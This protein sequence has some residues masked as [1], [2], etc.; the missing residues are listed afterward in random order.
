LKILYFLFAEA[1][2]RRRHFAGA[3]A[4]GKKHPA[5]RRRLIQTGADLLIS[6][7]SSSKLIFAYF[8]VVRGNVNKAE[9]HKNKKYTY[10]MSDYDGE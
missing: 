10:K 7:S 6:S 3:A 2:D 8:D 5:R 9:L 4:A 1:A